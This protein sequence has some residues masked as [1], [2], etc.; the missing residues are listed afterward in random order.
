[1]L[2]SFWKKGTGLFRQRSRGG[3]ARNRSAV[4]DGGEGGSALPLRGEVLG[5]KWVL[6]VKEGENSL[7]SGEGKEGTL[8]I[9]TK[10][11]KRGSGRVRSKRKEG[12]Y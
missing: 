2:S 12:N 8:V 5:W 6:Q 3:T 4:E 11:R 10:G 9:A 7:I 1:M